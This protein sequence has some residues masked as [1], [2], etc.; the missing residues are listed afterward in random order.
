MKNALTLGALLALAAAAPLHAQEYKTRFN[1]RQDR[2]LVLEM[3]G[4][5]VTVEGYDGDEVVIRG[6]TYE[7][8]PKQAEGLRPLYNT[9]EDNTR[10]G[11]SV[12][13][14]GS[15]LRVVQAGRHKADYVIRVPRRTALEFTQTSWT[16]GN[17]R[18]TDLEGSV[19]L[20]LKSGNAQLTNVAGPVVASSTNGNIT[21]RFAGPQTAPSS[22]S[23][24]NGALDVTLP[25]ATKATLTLR[26]MSGEI[27]S[28]FELATVKAPDNLQR[29]GGGHT[30]SGSLNGGGVQ[31]ALKTINGDIFLRKAK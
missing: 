23:A 25:A 13:P 22:L 3:R 11:L 15:T 30:I 31:M 21:V 12:T 26:S 14:S 17:V 7:P 6:G 8:A 27:Y 24:I 19:E 9:A 16:G 18:V 29:V 5:N 4:S 20:T 1:G 10:Q 28:G 2:K